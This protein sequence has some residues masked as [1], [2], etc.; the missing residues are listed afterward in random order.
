MSSPEVQPGKLDIVLIPGP[1]PSLPVDEESKRW[2]AAHA[3]VP[4]TDIL[5]V[6]TGAYICGAAG[7]LKGKKF[8]GPRGLQDDLKTKFGDQG[9]TW[10]GGELR[11]VQDGN[12]WSSGTLPT[13][14]VCLGLCRG[15]A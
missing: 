5:S 4:T 12:I 3:A 13:S 11:W 15:S 14:F 2:L 7:I 6:C 1:D 10:L 9:V 8:C